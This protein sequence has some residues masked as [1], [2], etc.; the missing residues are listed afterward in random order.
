M[1]IVRPAGPPASGRHRIGRGRRAGFTLLEV[2]L[3]SA[4]AVILMAALYVALDVQLKLADAGREAI[5]QATVSRALVQ[6]F[7]SD[8]ANCLGPVAGAS[9]GTAT[10]DD[11]GDT[12]EGM[13][14][15]G[16][17]AIPFAAGVIGEAGDGDSGKL[18]LYVCKVPKE[19]TDGLT[20]ADV[21][22]VTYWMTNKGL[23]RQ[24]VPWVTSERLQ[25]S[26]DLYLDDGREPDSYVIAE[27]VTRVQFSYWDG[28][29]WQDTWDGRGA[30]GT[31]KGPPMAVRV[32]FWMKVPGQE[33]PKE[34]RHTISL[35]AA[36]GPAVPE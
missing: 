32:T 3:A 21:R 19:V 27:E 24:E 16:S 6:R 26:T 7:E 20:P 4:L 18:T 2:L 11:T 8:M 14:V 23:A 1:R 25:L 13:E 33:E 5:E 31:V 22:R 10:E 30:D 29:A 28:S 17:T 35:L 12:P 9:T 36:P 15:T 34:F